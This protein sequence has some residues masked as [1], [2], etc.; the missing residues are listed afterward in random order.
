MGEGK[1]VGGNFVVV[2]G[3]VGVV[4]VEMGNECSAGAVLECAVG[5]RKAL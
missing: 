5:Q 2:V 4:D 1:G 3:G